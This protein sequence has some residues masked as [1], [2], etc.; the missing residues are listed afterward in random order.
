MGFKKF[1]SGKLSRLATLGGGLL[2]ASSKYAL[3]KTKSK[4]EKST[5]DN[6][7]LAQIKAAKE[8][9]QTMG[10]LKGGLM[11]LGQMLSI[12]EDLVLPKEISILFKNLQKD[13]PPMSFTDIDKA[14]L[15]AFNK[16]PNEV[17]DYFEYEALAS[18][19]IGQVHKAII[20]TG[21]KVVVKI[22]YPKI[23]EA[24]QNDFQN[25][26]KLKSVLMKV[27]PGKID[28]SSV[29]NELKNSM[30][31]ECDYIHEIGELNFFR[32]ALREEFPNIIIPKTFEDYSCKSILTMEYLEGMSFDESL[33]CSQV[34]K[35][36]WGQILYD[37]FLYTLYK[38][39]HMHT[40]PQNGNYL[41]LP[42]KIIMLDF[43][44]TRIFDNDFVEAYKNLL[45][46][47]E[48]EDFEL[49]KISAIQL[50][51]CRENDPIEHFQKHY[52]LV[53]TMYRP[54]LRSGKYP[55][56]DLNPFQIIREYIKNIDLDG[57]QTPRDEFV[58]L[59]RANIGLFSKLSAWN[60]HIDWLTSKVKYRDNT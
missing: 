30:E 60:S 17:F 54:H 7:Y 44:S 23:V 14:F 55:I 28:L 40:D 36:E 45:L 5:A 35:D 9:V 22:Q 16:L 11:K 52:D 29:V 13:A 46:S 27:I 39:R 58:L 21:E 42:G 25:I 20:S 6:Q 10:E 53:A 24:V 49:Y 47:V 41:F 56:S 51:L 34:E 26:D 4:F 37:S 12:T 48:V 18:A 2:K 33:N 31:R 57:R 43:G 1:S 8:I 38:L 59:D 19:S 15:K 50:D 3:E 32:E